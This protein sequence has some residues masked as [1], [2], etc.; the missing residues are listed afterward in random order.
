MKSRTPDSLRR[1]SI[2]QIEQ[3]I[4]EL[5]LHHLAPEDDEPFDMGRSLAIDRLLTETE[6]GE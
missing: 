4:R 1:Y 3:L 5:E 2:E 6:E